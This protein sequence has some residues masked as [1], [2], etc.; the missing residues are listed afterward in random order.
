MTQEKRNRE[1]REF[2]EVNNLW[3]VVPIYLRRFLKRK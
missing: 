1:Q 2:I 3:A